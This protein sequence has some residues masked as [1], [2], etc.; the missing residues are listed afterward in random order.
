VFL[1]KG[2]NS[3]KILLAPFSSKSNLLQKGKNNVP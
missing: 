1:P 2:V 3:V